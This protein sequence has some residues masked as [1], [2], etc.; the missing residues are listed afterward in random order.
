MKKIILVLLMLFCCGTALAESTDYYTSN[1]DTLKRTPRRSSFYINGGF[2]FDFTHISYNHEYHEQKVK[3]SG[4]G[5]GIVGDL[6]LGCLIKEFIAVYGSFEVVSYDGKYDLKNVKKKYSFI[7]DEINDIALLGGI[8]VTGFPFSRANNFSQG[9]FFGGKLLFGAI[10]MQEPFG[11][12]DNYDLRNFSQQ[13]KDY[14]V[15]GLDLELGKD[16]KISERISIGVALRWQFLG[17]VSGDDTLVDDDDWAN[18]EHNH[19]GNSV[20]LMLRL[21]RR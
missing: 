20:Q 6:S 2:G 19:M 16:W 4:N 11:N 5:F 14:F 1:S 8:G 7:D 21:N 18:Y 15:I 12:Y 13:D 3:Y 9:I 10:M 17:I